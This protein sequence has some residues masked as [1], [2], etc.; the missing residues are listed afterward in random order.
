MLFRYEFAEKL[1]LSIF[2]KQAIAYISNFQ[3]LSYHLVFPDYRIEVEI[4]SSENSTAH[5]AAMHIAEIEKDADGNVIRAEAIFPRSDLRFKE[6]KVINEAF[7]LDHYK[8]T[9]ESHN[10]SQTVETICQLAKIV[11]K[12]NNLKAFL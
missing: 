11:H 3:E 8:T 6:I 5:L 10:V 4:V 7:P 2:R 9:I 12:I 1:D